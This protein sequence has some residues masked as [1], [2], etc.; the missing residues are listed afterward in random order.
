[1]ERQLQFIIAKITDRQD[2]TANL[3]PGLAMVIK[4]GGL[5]C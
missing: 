1:M 4:G 3:A 2:R 5:K